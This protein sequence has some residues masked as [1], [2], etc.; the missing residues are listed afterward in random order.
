MYY[1]KCNEKEKVKKIYSSYA[2][3][4]KEDVSGCM[5]NDLRLWFVG[6]EVDSGST[7]QE[8]SG[9]SGQS[10]DNR[11]EQEPPGEVRTGL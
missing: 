10:P 6:G 5:F 2:R 8:T 1:A 11:T 3:I 7:R 9:P 4:C